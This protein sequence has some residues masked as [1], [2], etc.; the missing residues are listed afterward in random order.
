MGLLG[1]EGG[2][3][4]NGIGALKT[5]A[6]ESS[7][8]LPPRGDTARSHRTQPRGGPSPEHSHAGTAS[9]MPSLHICEK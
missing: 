2:A 9:G 7:L 1:R 5:E 8:A 6:R 3:L 4:Q